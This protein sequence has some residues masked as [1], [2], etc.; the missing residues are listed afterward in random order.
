MK[1]SIQLRVLAAHSIIALSA[2]ASAAEYPEQ[3]IQGDVH[4]SACAPE[5]WEP[6]S[7]AVR[8]SAHKHRPDLLVALVHTYLCESG[9]RATAALRSQTTRKVTEIWENSEPGTDPESA[10]VKTLISR[11][12][13]ETRAGVAWQA[14]VAREGDLVYLSFW[15]DEACVMSP[16]FRFKGGRWQ[17]FARSNGCD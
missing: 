3:N 16:H 6:L 7:R 9:N 2:S 5:N 15:S 4:A 12:S 11:D 1:A 17:L 14:S 10:I 8:Q 13:I